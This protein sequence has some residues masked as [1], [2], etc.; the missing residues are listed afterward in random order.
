MKSLLKDN[1]KYGL[2]LGFLAPALGV[3]IY[4]YWKIYP[5]SLRIF[6]EYLHMEKRLLS[7][8]TVV[9]LLMN[10]ALF[11]LFVNTRKDQTAKGIFIFTL[12]YAI[13][14]LTVKFFM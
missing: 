7:S 5:N 9:C 2:L 4:Y 12:I 11:T 3:L 14:S 6:F 8:L 10:V 1:L 13:L